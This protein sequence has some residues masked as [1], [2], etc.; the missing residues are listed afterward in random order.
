ML[1]GAALWT[2]ALQAIDR[3]ALI[4]VLI[5]TIFIPLATAYSVR[6]IFPDAGDPEGVEEGPTTT[7]LARSLLDHGK[8]FGTRSDRWDRGFETS[9][10]I[11]SIEKSELDPRPGR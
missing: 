9:L 4:R 10:T 5:S 6:L 11:G 8:G 1:I 3:S 2:L 7:S